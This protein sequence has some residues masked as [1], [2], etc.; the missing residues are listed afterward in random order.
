MSV[1]N[2]DNNAPVIPP[3]P[4]KHPMSDSPIIGSKAQSVADKM[5]ADMFG[6]TE[7]GN[8]PEKTTGQEQPKPV[9][10]PKEGEPTQVEDQAD[11]DVDDVQALIDKKKGKATDKN[12]DKRKEEVQREIDELMSK[13]KALAAEVEAA[14]KSTKA[15]TDKKDELPVYSEQ[16]LASA[17]QKALEDQDVALLMQIQTYRE[18]R[19]KKELISKYEAEKSKSTGQQDALNKEWNQV[20]EKFSPTAYEKEALKSDTDFDV[21]NPKSMLF[22]LAKG[23]YEDPELSQVYK[24]PGGMLLATQDAFNEI[25]LDRLTT[26]TKP[27]GNNSQKKDSLRTQ[28][29]KEK[30]KN[31]LGAGSESAGETPSI[32]T[33]AKDDLKSYIEERR[34]MKG[35]GMRGTQLI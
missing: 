35:K 8:P 26:G 1:E 4:S 13:K 30:R 22:R 11:G 24:K 14:E 21:T 16:E 15:A 10:A 32:I 33:A 23:L 28:L 29:E 5:E 17:T 19:L 6:P 9:V 25:V 27:A 7:T 34:N 3:Q 18:E 31:T 20:K 12:V 2:Q